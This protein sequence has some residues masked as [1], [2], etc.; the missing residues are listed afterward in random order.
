MRELTIWL[1]ERNLRCQ[2]PCAVAACMRSL[3]G[4]NLL[5]ARLAGLSP[6]KRLQRRDENRQALRRPLAT[7]NVRPGKRNMEKTPLGS[8]S[9]RQSSHL[10]FCGRR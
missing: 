5:T 9:A 10:W 1:S 6:R 3:G 7:A 8:G 2:A 4:L